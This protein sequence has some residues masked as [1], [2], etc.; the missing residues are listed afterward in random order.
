[1]RLL[2]LNNSY[3]QLPERFFAHT[4]PK[5]VSE[6]RLIRFNRPLAEELGLDADQLT[7]P[8]GLDM[9]SGHRF[10]EGLQAIA[11]AYAGHQFGNFVPQLGDG[12]AL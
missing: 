2:A 10:P 9:L 7:S 11:L 5:P 4:D 12:R 6:P 1:M 3:A 8:D